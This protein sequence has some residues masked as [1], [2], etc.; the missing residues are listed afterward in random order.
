MSLPP[1]ISKIRLPRNSIGCISL[2]FSPCAS[3]EMRSRPGSESLR[4]SHKRVK[5]AR[6]SRRCARRSSVETISGPAVTMS[7]QNVSLRRSSNGKSKSVASI[8]VVNSMETLS[9]QS[10]VSPS[11][12]ESRMRPARARMVP[13][14]AERLRGATT[15]VTVARCTSCLGG[16]IAINIGVRN[17]FALSAWDFNGPIAIPSSE[18]KRS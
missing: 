18:E 7:D 8:C 11:G 6:H 10:N 13:S 1:T 9:T 3:M 15:G 17:S 14:R 4:S 16:S 5:N 12:R 2:V